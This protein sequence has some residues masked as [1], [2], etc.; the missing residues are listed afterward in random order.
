[1]YIERYLS[2]IAG[3]GTVSEIAFYTPFVTHILRGLLG[4]PPGN[5]L[6]N[7]TGDTGTPDIRVRSTQDQSEWVVCEVKLEDAEIRNENRRQRIWQEQV[8]GKNYITAETVYAVLCAPRTFRIYDPSGQLVAGVDLLPEQNQFRDVVTQELLPLNDTELRGA[9][10]LLSAEAAIGRPQY[11]AFRSGKLE[12]GYIPLNVQTVDRLRSVFEFG[13]KELKAYCK[14]CFDQL[15]AE[16]AIACQK[17]QALSQQ[18]EMIGSDEQLLERV[19][20]RERAIKRRYRIAFQL[21]EEDYPQF[22]HDQAYAGTKEEAHF[23][24]IF[25]TNTAYIALSRLFFVRICE[26][27]GLTT[28]KV[29]HQGLGVW[30]QFVRYIKQD[31]KDLLDIAYL[32]VAPIY[33]RLFEPTVFDWFGAGNGKL[34]AILERI[35]LRLNAFSFAKVDRDLL[36]T[37]YQYFRPRAER[38]RLGEYYT[39]EEVV[40]YILARTGI[41]SD[42]ALMSR[43]ILDPSCGSFTFGVRAIQALLRAGEH[44]S[45]RHKIALVQK[46][47]AGRDINPFSV[48]LSHL[49]LLFTML[50][51]YREAKAESPDFLL[52]GF[53][54][55]NVNSLAYET[56]QREL[57]VEAEEAS[58]IEDSGTEGIA[59]LS[60]DYVVGNPPFVRNERLPEEDREA[61]DKIYARL[62]S[63]NTD[64]ATYFLHSALRSWLK[65]GGVLGMVAPIGQANA[66]NAA[67]L[68][69][70]L[71]GYTIYEIVSLEWMAKEVFPD[72]DIIPMLLFIKKAPPPPDHKITVVT[73]LASKA[74]LSAART[75]TAFRAARASEMDY[76]DWLRI[77]PTG[78]W[79]L[80]ITARDMPILQKLSEGP[81]LETAAHTQFGIK[82]GSAG[83]RIARPLD[84]TRRAQE[85]AFAKG[86]HLCAFGVSR[87]DEVLDLAQIRN[88]SD[89]SLWGDLAFYE[90]NRGRRN[91]TGS[92]GTTFAN[93]SLLA[94]AL[95]SDTL[96]CLIPKIYTT[97]VAT[98][99]HPLELAVNDSAIVAIPRQCSA[100]VLAAIINSRI[101]RYYAF[102]TMRAAILLRRRST[103]YPRALNHLPWP[104]LTAEAARQLHTLAIE[105]AELSRHAQ[106][107]DIEVYLQALASVQDKTSAGFLGVY[108][109]GE[110]RMIDVE[111]LAAA[112]P[113]GSRL[114]V[115]TSAL[116][117]PDADILLLTCMAARASEETFFDNHA[118]QSLPLPAQAEERRRV[119]ESVRA[120]AGHVEAAQARMNTITEEID[121]LV[122]AGLGLT[123]AEH[124]TIRHRCQEFP[125]NVT[126]GR[127][128]YVWNPDRKAQAR[129][130]YEEG[131]RFRQ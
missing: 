73:G 44:L 106:R 114:Q 72:A 32:D 13:L 83:A 34:N 42:S 56:G 39:P 112:S 15:K 69:A 120:M 74:E 80:D 128:R 58:Q 86:H 127:P 89:A 79:P 16:Y 118:F 65:E 100:P 99:A 48:F 88:V 59:S 78:D 47:I 94:E 125:L 29:S 17:R 3:A 70:E 126:V 90:A 85:I 113:A 92:N 117:A 98:V 10:Y 123:G 131:R 9:L 31:Y 36:G 60:F 129:R 75:D 121:A 91:E 24:D 50:D 96:C 116:H 2:D 71:A 28:R 23:E 63:G 67:L 43:R 18:R 21:F 105:A 4:Y 53:D 49:S 97:L 119:A 51:V 33:S 130:I 7:K 62:R 46:V 19:R 11:E 84:A 22:R 111:D 82:L 14:A 77:S 25:L 12:G 81:R 87:P 101:C 55:A 20:N 103:W 64:L 61:L 38:K 108:L 35:L 115:G 54:I 27:I 37:V 110:Q 76:A 52:T 1:V 66:R 57:P 124:D 45:A 95:P 40:D 6:I 30:S 93:S 107:T 41:V 8:V 26:D 102:L 109:Q 122:A 68:R 104:A 5:C